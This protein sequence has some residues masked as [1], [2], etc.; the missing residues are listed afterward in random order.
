[1]NCKVCKNEIKVKGF[2]EKLA[3]RL[4]S[5]G[6]CHSCDGWMTLWQHRNESHI[7]RINGQHY[8]ITADNDGIK[9]T[10]RRGRQL[11]DVNLWH[12]GTIPKEFLDALPDNAS[13]ARRIKVIAG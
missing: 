13:F 4:L 7:V 11:F 3:N 2:Y 8:M 6:I 9:A 5:A 10:I 12:Q 1:M